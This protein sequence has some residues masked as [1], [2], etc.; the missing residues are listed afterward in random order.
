[1]KKI[2]IILIALLSIF[3]LVACD[4]NDDDE[5][6]NDGVDEL[7]QLEPDLAGIPDIVAEVNDKEISGEEFELTYLSQFQQFALQAQMSGQEIDQEQLKKELAESMIDQELLIQEANHRDF[8]AT[9][10][11]I[12]TMINDLVEMN[13]LESEQALFDLFAEQ[14]MSEEQVKEEL[15]VQIKLEQL[16]DDEAKDI[17]VSQEEIQDMYDELVAMY[18]DTEEEVP[19]YDDIEADLEEQ[20][21]TQ[22]KNEIIFE[23]IEQLRDNAEIVNHF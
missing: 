21:I 11:E 23:L 7:E 8:V 16:V 19:D 17:T 13:D 1:M 3:A 12:E 15:S 10:D 14:G 2:Q 9:D 18:E 4:S 22:E 6:A 20:M 5:Q